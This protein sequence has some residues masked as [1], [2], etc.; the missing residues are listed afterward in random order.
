MIYGPDSTAQVTIEAAEHIRRFGALIPFSVSSPLMPAL[1]A[2]AAAL[3][4]LSADWAYPV[5]VALVYVAGMLSVYWIVRRFRSEPAAALWAALTYGAAPSRLS[6]VIGQPDGPRLLFWTLALVFLLMADDPRRKF[7]PRRAA[8]MVLCLAFLLA[9]LPGSFGALDALALLELAVLLALSRRQQLW[10]NHLVKLACTAA[11][12]VVSLWNFLIY[13]SLV[14]QPSAMP[15]AALDWVRA[16]SDKPRVYGPVSAQLLMRPHREAI[17]RII[18]SPGSTRDSLMWLRAHAAEYLISMDW[19]KFHSALECVHQ[20]GEWCV[21]RIPAYNPAQ[22]VLVSRD[23]RQDLKPI[24]GP[25]DR[26]GLEAYL[27]WSGRPEAAGVVWRDSVSAEIHADLGP[28]DAILV[29]VPARPGWK[30]A[31]QD[32]TGGIRPIEVQSDPAGFIL[33][34]PNETGPARITLEYNPG[35][36]ERLLPSPREQGPFVRGDFPIIST[37]GVVDAFDYTPPPFKS[38]ALLSIFGRYFI[39]GQTT[40]FIGEART[41]PTYAGA[42]QINFQLPRQ[43]DPGPVEIVVESGGRRSYPYRAEVIN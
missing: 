43:L 13:P 9:T 33:L 5:V 36:L 16:N 17:D 3:T 34:D 15:E 22:A 11:F 42:T 39:P 6:S 32:S 41:T 7:R 24:R 4:G 31:V 30:A 38:G 27:N 35:W 29:R 37:D 26:E 12:F 25:L 8:G 21:Y 19:E 2:L 10:S 1:V 18:L 40:V 23:R 28:S 20:Q 14:Y